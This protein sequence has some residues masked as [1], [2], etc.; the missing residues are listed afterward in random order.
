M[1]I[2]GFRGRFAPSPTG[3]MHLGNARTALLAWLL[4]REARGVMI[5]RIEDLD[6][7]RVR[8]GAEE[9]LLH[10]LSWLG[11]TWDEG[12]DVGGRFGPYRQS[13]RLEGYER[14]ISSLVTYPCTCTRRE[15]LDAIQDSASA[16]HGDEPRYAGTCRDGPTHPERPAALRLRVPDR[17]VCF[18]DGL[19]GRVC[20]DVQETVGDFVVRRNDGVFAYQLACVVDDHEMRV[21]DVLRGQDL[22]ESTPRQVMLHGLLGASPPHFCHVPLMTDYRG[23][24]LAKRGGAP[25]LRALREGGTNPQD[26]VRDLALSLGWTVPG[27]CRPTDLIGM[28]EPWLQEVRLERS[29]SSHL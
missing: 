16:P 18:E 7:T 26:V 24:R 4:A 6:V 1:I 12:P 27:P 14:A 11:L 13:E 2:E 23:Q 21:T 19:N 22:L 29:R 5:L 9:T 28:L 17:T 15:I 8:P 25:S 3:E 10:D 20:R